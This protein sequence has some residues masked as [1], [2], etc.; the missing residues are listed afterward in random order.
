MFATTSPNNILSNIFQLHHASL[1][2]EIHLLPTIIWILNQV[3][4]D[5]LSPNW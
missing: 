3:Q 2:S 1:S 4:N 5:N